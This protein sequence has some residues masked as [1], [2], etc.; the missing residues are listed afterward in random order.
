MEL[1][2]VALLVFYA[3]SENWPRVPKMGWDATCNWE[4]NEK[5]DID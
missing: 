4:K 1:K 3:L 5:E 2:N